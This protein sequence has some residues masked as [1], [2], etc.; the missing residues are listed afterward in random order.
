MFGK[1]RQKSP[2]AP[3]SVSR[4]QAEKRAQDHAPDGT[5]R[6]GNGAARKP[7]LPADARELLRLATQAQRR[8]EALNRAFDKRVADADGDVSP[9][10]LALAKE[11]SEQ[12]KR[13]QSL[14]EAVDKLSS[15]ERPASPFA[16]L[17][18]AAAA[19]PDD[20]VA[21]VSTNDREEVI[22]SLIGDEPA[23]MIAPTKIAAIAKSTA[24]CEP[25]VIPDFLNG[26]KVYAHQQAQ[27]IAEHDLWRRERERM[28]MQQP[29][30]VLQSPPPIPMPP[31]RPL[32]VSMGTATLGAPPTLHWPPQTRALRTFTPEEIAEQDKRN[33]ELRA[34]FEKIQRNKSQ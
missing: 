23:E 29:A 19:L 16:E 33:A 3:I 13:A 25:G 9:E 2:A 6:P 26:E 10:A 12:G 4:E 32:G 11:A 30:P 24:T 1:R 22:A 34:E 27:K 7:R 20:K 5:F 28:G 15:P 18:A 17:L 21:T 14:R 31:A 8:A